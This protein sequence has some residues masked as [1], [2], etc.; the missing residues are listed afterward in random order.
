MVT[1]LVWVGVGVVLVVEVR[2]LKFIKSY[3]LSLC[4]L[5][6]FKV[7]EQGNPCGPH[8]QGQGKGKDR[9]RT[10]DDYYLISPINEGAMAYIP[11][12]YI[13]SLPNHHSTLTGN[14]STI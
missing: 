14:K 13:K 2:V 8:L 3:H 5:V 10:T 12:A 7:H 9:V 11:R 4:L 6:E 1:S